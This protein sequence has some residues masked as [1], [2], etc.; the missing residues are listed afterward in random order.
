MA[1]IRPFRGVRYHPVM[2][3]D[4]APVICPPYDIIPPQMQSALY[5][6]S[7][8]NFIRLE[9][10]R[11]LPDDN[12]SDNKYTRSSSTLEQ[13]LAQ[14]I[15]A[16]DEAPAIYL[17]DHYF[18]Y[19]DEEYRRR[20][21]I[22]LVRLEEWESRAIRPHEGTLADPR[23]DRL[24][25]LRVL[26]ANTSPILSLYEDPERRIA[27]VLA[28]RAKDEPLLHF[29]TDNGDKHVLWAISDVAVLG[30]IQQHLARQPLYIADGHHR[31]ESA[32]AYRREQRGNLAGP[33]KDEGFDFVMMTLVD[34]ADPGLVIL[35]LH[36]LVRGL[37][38][39][40]I[41]V[42]L[43]G[44]TSFFQIDELPFHSSDVW[45]KVDVFLNEAE[46]GRIVLFTPGGKR[47]LLLKPHDFKSLQKLM[48]EDS[49]EHYKKLAVSILDHVIL[50]K[51]LSLRGEKEVEALAYSYDQSN[52]ASMVL[53]GEYQ[54]AFLIS[55]V[56]A[57]MV[58]I[59]ADVGERMPRKSTY[60][61]PK[62]PSGLVFYR[63]AGL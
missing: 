62:L 31:Y 11:T 26:Q 19:Q 25:L 45:Q 9:H 10:A 13:W 18:Q 33:S 42:A 21:I 57:D 46:P 53:S 44:L 1:D 24:T 43:N 8:F 20:G 27:L 37:S 63:M 55:P 34:F 29:R 60:F 58:K 7:E 51:L 12:N 32:L 16:V 40:K 14:G 39:K 52:A 50:E 28:A 3:N 4:L 48:P 23:S 15:L 47:L 30:Q 17:H 35:P 5:E 6:R 2:V 61:Y 59:V 22:A 54:M 49:S 36:R 41:G 38:T 56:K